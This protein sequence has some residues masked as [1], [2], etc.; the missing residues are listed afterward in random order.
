MKQTG[1]NLVGAATHQKKRE[2]RQRLFL[3]L[4]ALDGRMRHPKHQQLLRDLA[5]NLDLTGPID[6]TKLPMTPTGFT[7]RHDIADRYREVSFVALCELQ[8]VSMTVLYYWL[9]AAIR[10]PQDLRSC[11]R[12]LNW[13]EEY[14][15]EPDR[16][17]VMRDRHLALYL[18]P[19]KG[20]PDEKPHL[21]EFLE[22]DDGETV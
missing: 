18:Y 2:I 8:V 19:L 17:V 10:D 20:V 11:E 22:E 21:P 7:V 16:Y 3:I 1:V 13:L 14:T 15:K 4:R 5:C 9:Y 6:Q 12:Y